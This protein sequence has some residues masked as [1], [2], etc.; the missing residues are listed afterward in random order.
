[1]FKIKT[2]IKNNIKELEEIEKLERILKEKKK[3]L[4][5]TNRINK[6]KNIKKKKISEYIWEWLAVTQWFIDD[7]IDFIFQKLS[8][9]SEKELPKNAPIHK[10]ITYHTAWFVWWIWSSYYKKYWEIKQWPNKAE[11]LINMWKMWNK[12]DIKNAIK[13]QIKKGKLTPEEISAILKD[14]N[15]AIDSQ[16]DLIKRKKENK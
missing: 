3:K 9:W 7:S 11:M 4:K 15:K 13:L 5:R 1:M 10:K 12:N 2:P 16:I 8:S 6:L 14:W